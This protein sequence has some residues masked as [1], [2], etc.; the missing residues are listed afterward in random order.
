MCAETSDLNDSHLNLSTPS[1]SAA[2]REIQDL[3]KRV[4]VFTGSYIAT[5]VVLNPIF[6]Y[7][8]TLPSAQ[9]VLSERICN[10]SIRFLT[11]PLQLMR[12]HILKFLPSIDMTFRYGLKGQINWTFVAVAAGCEELIYR[13]LI[14]SVLFT[15]APKALLK[16]IS[17][18]HEYLVDHKVVKAARVVFTSVLFALLHIARVGTAPGLLIPQFVMGVYFSVMREQQ[19]S[20]TELSLQHFMINVIS[21]VMHGGLAGL[22]PQLI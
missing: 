17:P 16:R 4:L 3:A 13:G 11:Y 2:V 15:E 14:Q 8:K 18:Q 19:M 22:S 6:V 7:L 10:L 1:F 21:I 9:S 12:R 5:V 20:L